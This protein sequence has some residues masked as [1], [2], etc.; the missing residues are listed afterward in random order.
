LSKKSKYYLGPDSYT[1]TGKDMGDAYYGEE[2][3]SQFK[4]DRTG[5]LFWFTE[6]VYRNMKEVPCR[7]A[8]SK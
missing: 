1:Y 7:G 5:E 2:L 8:S 4:N 6:D 3:S